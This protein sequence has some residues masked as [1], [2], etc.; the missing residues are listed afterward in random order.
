MSRGWEAVA[1]ELVRARYGALVGFATTLT[2]SRPAAE[3]LV[4]EALVATFGKNRRLDSIAAAEAYVRRA[5]ATRYVDATRR[6]IRDRATVQRIA[7]QPEQ[8]ADAADAGVGSPEAIEDALAALSPKERACV[9]LRHLEQLSTRETASVLGLS[10]GAVKRY[11]YDG[12]RKL[13]RGMLVDL[14]LEEPEFA[15]VANREEVRRG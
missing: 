6:A 1:T 14:P 10:D 13:S 7:A 8:F 3:D 12:V 4:Q 9:V 15:A 2:G 11:L 5:I